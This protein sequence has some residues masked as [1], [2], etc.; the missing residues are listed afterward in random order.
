V[1]LPAFPQHKRTYTSPRCNP[2]ACTESVPNR[3]AYRKLDTRLPKACRPN[4]P[5]ESVPNPY[6]EG[7][8]E[9]PALTYPKRAEP[10]SLPK[11]RLVPTES[12]LTERLCPC[13]P[14]AHRPKDCIRA[15]RKRTLCYPRCPTRASKSSTRPTRRLA[16]YDGG[17]P[18]REGPVGHCQRCRDLPSGSENT[19]A[20]R[21]FVKKEQLARAKII[22]SIEKSQ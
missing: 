21:A 15:Y 13:L 10:S 2:L 18:H 20:V 14:K 4:T 8:T 19:K 22:L 12:T 17:A 5:N 6:C 16:I 9:S 3:R 7:P 1:S 11:A